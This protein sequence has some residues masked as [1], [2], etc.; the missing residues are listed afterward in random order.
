MTSLRRAGQFLAEPKCLIYPSGFNEHQQ[1]QLRRCLRSAGAGVMNQLTSSVTHVIVNTT[2]LPEHIKL[3]NMLKLTP[4][5][6]SLQWLVESMHLTMAVP[7][8]D[9]YVS[10]PEIHSKSSLPSAKIRLGN[11][12]GP[13]SRS[14]DMTIKK[15][16]YDDTAINEDQLEEDILA[17]YRNATATPKQLVPFENPT[18]QDVDSDVGDTTISFKLPKN[19]VVDTIPGAEEN[20]EENCHANNKRNPLHNS[21]DSYV[22]SDELTETKE[23]DS[24]GELFFARMKFSLFGFDEENVTELSECVEKLGGLVVQEDYDGILN[25]LIVPPISDP[26]LH[27]HFSAQ[28]IVSNYWLEDCLEQGYELEIQYYHHPI[29]KVNESKSCEGIV[30]GI[31]GYISK[32]R[33]FISTVAESLGMIAQEIFAKR[34]K[35][36]ALRSTHLVCANPEGAKYEAGIKW[37]LPVVNKDWLLACLRDNDWVSEKQFLVGDATKFT[38]GKLEPKLDSAYK[39]ETWLTKGTQSLKIKSSQIKK[40]HSNHPPHYLHSS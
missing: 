25:Y 12:I 11:P 10:V 21:K 37:D 36:G 27:Q 8:S 34:D 15:P 40:D 3:V 4:H 24:E 35:R 2:L 29:Y 14:N 28:N 30:I 13:Q 17:Q 16:I 1:E 20:M 5:F 32:E 26:S 6:V 18:E 33:E 19:I 31:T 23:H 9:F 39:Y 7:E 22:R 38:T